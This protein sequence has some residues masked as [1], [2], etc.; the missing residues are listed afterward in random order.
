MKL[1]IYVGRVVMGN[2]SVYTI[3]IYPYCYTHVFFFILRIQ[4]PAPFLQLNVLTESSCFSYCY[5]C[6][7]KFSGVFRALKYPA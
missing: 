2:V 1:A 5:D 6:I 7:Q 4:F 3:R